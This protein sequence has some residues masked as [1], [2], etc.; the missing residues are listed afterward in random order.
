MSDQEALD[1]LTK[2]ANEDD[3]KREQKEYKKY[4]E[5]GDKIQWIIERAKHYEKITL[6]DYRTV[7]DL[8]ESKRNMSYMNFYQDGKQPLLEGENIFL[9]DDWLNEAV[10]LFGKDKMKWGFVCPSCKHDQTVADFEAVGTDPANAYLHCIGRHNKKEDEGCNWAAYGLFNICD[11]TVIDTNF[12]A[13]SVFSFS[14]KGRL[15]EY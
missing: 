9:L 12:L 4:T 11:I 10:K 7:I 13:H 6:V 2:L 5:H 15:V 8:W 1:K 14:E 3:K